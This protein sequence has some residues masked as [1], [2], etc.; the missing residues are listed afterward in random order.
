MVIVKK[1]THLITFQLF[2]EGM[3]PFEIAEKRN[4][5][6][7]TVYRHL[8]KMGLTEVERTF[9]MQYFS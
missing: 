2:D 9:R 4:I 8:A 7:S 6:L 5:M 1:Q 3:P